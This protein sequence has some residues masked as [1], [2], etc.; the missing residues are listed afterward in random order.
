MIEI[1]KKTKNYVIIYKHA[2]VPS[3]SDPSG[4]PDAMSLTSKALK[5]QGEGDRLWLI[6]RLDRVVGGVMVFARSKSSA[7]ALSEMVKQRLLTKE[8]YAVVDGIA[9]GGAFD[10]LLYKDAS[11]GKSF[12]VD[13]ERAGVKKARLSYKKLSAVKTDKGEK[14]LV[15]ITLDTGRFHQIRTQFS[16][17]GMPIVGDGKY[18]SHDGKAHGIALFASHIEFDIGHDHAD[19]SILPSRDIYPW[20]LFSPEDYKN[21]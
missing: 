17:R 19:I 4:D 1:L 6:H 2:G 18:G 7:A 15:Y 3:Q 8:Y 10:D 21:L 20:S 16:Y 5:E 14:T 9:E 13:R 11:K 12:V